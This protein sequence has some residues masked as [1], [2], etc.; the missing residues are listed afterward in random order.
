MV[1]R[2]RSFTVPL[3][4]DRWNVSDVAAVNVIRSAH[5]DP[6][7][8]CWILPVSDVSV[9]WLVMW[10][11]ATPPPVVPPAAVVPGVATPVFYPVDVAAARGRSIRPPW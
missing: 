4:V 8:E 1:N 6:D 7:V 2:V 9:D 11:C 3:T 10:K 5:V